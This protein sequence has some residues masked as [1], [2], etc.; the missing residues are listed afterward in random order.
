[1]GIISSKNV[2]IVMNVK[3]G[4]ETLT[5]A[6]LNSRNESR[7]SNFGLDTR[8][9]DVMAPSAVRRLVPSCNI[10]PS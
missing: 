1:M 7:K 2:Y 8:G 4:K 6:E 9:D 10:L 3:Q 5:E